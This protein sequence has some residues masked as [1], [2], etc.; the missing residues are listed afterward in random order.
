MCIASVQPLLLGDWLDFKVKISTKLVH[1]PE[2]EVP[3]E[4]VLTNG[5]LT[6]YN[7]FRQE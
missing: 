3:R 1:N 6:M 7:E 2:F 5:H 4:D